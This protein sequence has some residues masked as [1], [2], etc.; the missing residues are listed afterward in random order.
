MH[1]VWYDVFCI[2]DKAWR[3]IVY[4]LFPYLPYHKQLN[5]ILEKKN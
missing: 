2:N 5:G 3:N 4:F 1:N